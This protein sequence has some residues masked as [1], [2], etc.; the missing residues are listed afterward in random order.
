MWGRQPNILAIFLEN[1]MVMK[2]PGP[3]GGGGGAGRHCWHS[4]KFSSP[5]P[6]HQ[7]ETRYKFGIQRKCE[8]D[9]CRPW[10]YKSPEYLRWLWKR[11]VGI[12]IRSCCN[13]TIL[14][15]SSVVSCELIIAGRSCWADSFQHILYQI[16][17]YSL[18][19]TT[20]VWIKS[21]D[22]SQFVRNK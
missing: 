13:R 6:F 15:L 9:L 7:F 2:K 8:Q 1:C 17:S 10:I 19:R 4:S 16:L 14:L 5:N 12:W 22:D 21:R 18:H 11:L 20:Y 3:L